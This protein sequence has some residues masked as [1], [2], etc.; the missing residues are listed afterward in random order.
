M[1]RSERSW[2]HRTLL[3]LAAGAPVEE[4]RDVRQW[5]ELA[6]VAGAHGMLGWLASKLR[7]SDAVPTAV[8]IQLQASALRHAGEHLEHLALAKRALALLNGAGVETMV[9][10]GPALVERYYRD[11]HIRP[12]GDV[13]LY[14]PPPRLEA[15]L[16]ALT[17][18]DDFKLIDRNWTFLVNDLRGQLHLLSPSRRTLE[19]HWHPVNDARQ[20]SALRMDPDELWDAAI[21]AQLDGVDC[22]VLPPGEEIA[23]LALH[24]A[25]HGC[26]RLIW[27]LDIAVMTRAADVDWDQATARLRRWSFGPGGWMVLWLSRHWLGARVDGDVLRLLEPGPGTRALFKTMVKRWDLSHESH[28]GLARELFMATAGSGPAT[29]L[30]L[31]GDFIVPAPGTLTAGRWPPALQGIRR[32]TLGTQRRLQEKLGGRPSEELL[33]EY[34]ASDQNATR[35]AYLESV[36]SLGAEDRGRPHVVVLSP[37][38]SIGMSHY[39]HAVAEAMRESSDV[40]LLDGAGGDGFLELRRR[41]KSLRK[42]PRSRLLVTSPHRSVPLLVWGWKRGG[43]FVFHDPILDAP[44]RVSRPLHVLYYRMLARRLGVVVIHGMAF[45]NHV[46]R[47]KLEARRIVSVPHGFVPH[48]LDL[49]AAYDP[50]G[51]MIFAGRLHPYKGLGVLLEA[52]RGLGERSEAIEVVLAGSGLRPDLV[53]AGLGRVTVRPGELSDEEFGLL[54]AR[55]SAVLLPYER[56]NQSGVLATAFR[57]GRPV[58][59]SAVGSFQEYVRDGENGLLVPPGD[60]DALG[61]AMDRLASDGDLAR[62]LAEGARRSWRDELSPQKGAAEIVAALD[63]Q[64]RSQRRRAGSFG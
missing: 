8:Q 60:A 55:C 45:R 64:R 33:S 18:H 1:S 19:L 10:K 25:M 26:N 30:R 14:V 40:T 17:A 46:L 16:A 49:D 11:P 20:R 13:D 12:Y 31:A 47:L 48:Q 24:T 50:G 6:A 58:I 53:P 2:A 56:A 34:R 43:G 15:A 7:G 61:E 21:P 42:D 3:E 22:F 37:S 36:K 44:S 35:E 63:A 51:P 32:V 28:A 57:A 4:A 23:H 29:R 54:I 59:A 9:L 52:L 62:R 39:A 27:L 38:R 5:E 41:L